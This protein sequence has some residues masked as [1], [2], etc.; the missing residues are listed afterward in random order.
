[1]SPIRKG[2]VIVTYG[3]SYEPIDEVRRITNHSTGKLGFLLSNRL[4]LAGWDVLCVKGLGATHH[5]PVEAGVERLPFGTNEHLCE[6]LAAI[7]KRDQIAA[8]FHAAALCD[9]KVKHLADAA[10]TPLEGPKISSR[11]GELT[12]TL[13]PAKKVIADLRSLFP[14]AKIVGWKYELAGAREEALAKGARQIAEN[15][16]DACVVNGRAFGPGFGVIE[17]GKPLAELPDKE[18]LCTWLSQWLE[19]QRIPD[20]RAFT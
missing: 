3:P 8:I 4:A 20:T 9:F 13:E 5:G 12:L 14:S 11:A 10:A 2:R 15:R 1:M 16:T 17:P 19:Q 18:T 6:R 7:P